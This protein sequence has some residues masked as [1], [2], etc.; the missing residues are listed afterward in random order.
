MHTR[1]LAAFVFSTTL[2]FAQQPYGDP[3]PGSGGFAP[4]LATAGAWLGNANHGYDILCANGNT[5]GFLAFATA[6][7]QLNVAG[8]T[9]LLDPAT[10]LGSVVFTTGGTG[11]G[12]GT[13]RVPLPLNLPP[14]PSFVG[15]PFFA[16]A[17]VVD[18]GAPAGL[19]AS[20]GVRVEL[21]LPPL[22]FVGCS[23]ANNDPFQLIDPLTNLV[24][25]SGSPTEVDNTTAAVFADGGTRLFVASSIR[26]T[27]G[28]ADVRTLPATWTTVFT[29]GGSCYGLA[30]DPSRGWLWTLT[31]PG[32]GTRE[33]TAIDIRQ[34]PT[35]GQI[36]ANTVGVATGN[37]ERWALSP[38]GRRAAML[39]LLPSTLTVIDT[40]AGS[41]TFLQNLQSALPIP[42][43]QASPVSLATRVAWLPDDRHALVLIQHA[44]TMPGEIAV[45]DSVAGV[46]VDH[47]TAVPGQQNIS[48]MAS[49]PVT[50]GSAPT[51]LG[52]ASNGT[53]AIVSGFGGCG[54]VGRLDLD[55][56]TPSF[57]AWTPWTPAASLQNAWTAGL[58][59]DETEV[60]IGTWQRSGC[61]TMGQPE[62]LRLD[63]VA[64]TVLGSVPIPAN[65]NSAT[66]QN[67]YTVVYR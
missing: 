19:A 7:Q 8:F 14:N 36:A 3:T 52:I 18:A 34:G 22:L 38:S 31:N 35:F 55:P 5:L 11:P 20:Q 2:L 53:F 61:P 16:Q 50:F 32:T 58:S 60:G 62:L 21:G 56:K 24:V 66:L 64:G 46:W 37:Y 42:L 4:R 29:G 33:L 25:D 12:Q 17:I 59:A 48:P 13:A 54:F 57:H 51:S 27:I 43:D 15:W 10:P 44:G 39:T 41:P 49:P 65:S 28:M 1:H 30:T 40:A 67:L 23:I 6:R 26:G 9:L 63:A 47:N 45:F